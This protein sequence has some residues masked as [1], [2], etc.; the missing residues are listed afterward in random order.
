M[1]N[2]VKIHSHFSGLG[3]RGSPEAPLGCLVRPGHGRQVETA[4]MQHARSIKN[5]PW[6]RYE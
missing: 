2:D 3:W 5:P 6:I 4:S 1:E